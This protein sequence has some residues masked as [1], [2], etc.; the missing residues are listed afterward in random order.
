MRN[1]FFR[2]SKLYCLGA[3]LVVVTEGAATHL[4]WE[5]MDRRERGRGWGQ[6]GVGEG[7]RRTGARTQLNRTLQEASGV[8]AICTSTV[9]L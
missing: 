8:A 2:V 1:L 3:S 7:G 9:S 6:V 5:A 4:K